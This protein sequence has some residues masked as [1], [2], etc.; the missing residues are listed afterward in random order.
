MPVR[1]HL[2]TDPGCA[3]SW[4]AE[5][6]RRALLVEFGKEVQI[7]YVMGGLARDYDGGYSEPGPL[8]EGMIVDWL[9]AA[10]GS[11]MP[12]DPRLWTESPLRSTYPACIA[13]KAAADQGP[14]AVEGYLRAVR[15]GI[16][17][18]RRRLD[19]R[20]PLVEVAREAGLDV[21]RFRVDVASNA[22]LEASGPTSTTPAAGLTRAP[23]VVGEHAVAGTA[24]YAD[25]RAAALAAGAQPLSDPRPDPLAALQRF[26]RMATVEVEEASTC[27][28]SRR[29][30]SS[31]GWPAAG[32]A[33]PIRVL[34]GPLWQAV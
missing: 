3:A 19:A 16:F 17:C 11:R 30:A 4:A 32:R 8:R 27:P 15:E 1:A 28:S 33:T 34:T 25:W 21:P 2:Y 14:E 10:A 20:E 23:L 29:R 13:V 6:R 18:F 7:T 12:T 24:P 26:G 31:G 22:V 9:D 5:P